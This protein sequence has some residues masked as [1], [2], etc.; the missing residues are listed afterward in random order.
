MV[1]NKFNN[2]RF[3]PTNQGLPCEGDSS[4][5][6]LSPKPTRVIPKVSNNIINKPP[7][8][9][10]RMSTLNCGSSSSYERSHVTGASLLC[11][12]LNPPPSP[13]TTAQREDYCCPPP[14]TP[15]STDVC[16][17]SDSNYRCDS[18]PFP[19]P[20]TPGSHS[21]GPPSPSSSSSTYFH[22]SP[23]G[24]CNR[25]CQLIPVPRRILYLIDFNYIANQNLFI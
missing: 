2:F 20:P 9:V 7:P 11:Y 8:A 14:P 13:A 24:R 22:P 1:I 4:A 6:P 19:P 5:D 12:P 15:C 21:S 10:V 16:D 17:E 23:N 18:D 25:L 3:S